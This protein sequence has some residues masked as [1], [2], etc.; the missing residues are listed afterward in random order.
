M[1][2][3]NSQN[4]LL[5][6]SN[7]R[8]PKAWGE[9]YGNRSATPCFIIKFQNRSK[10]INS[11]LQDQIKSFE[12]IY[13]HQRIQVVFNFQMEIV[14]RFVHLCVEGVGLRIYKFNGPAFIGPISFGMNKNVK[15][16]RAWESYMCMFSKLKLV[17]LHLSEVKLI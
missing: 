6:T 5:F 4:L 3:W 14:R 2:C 16:L 15:F 12:I 11:N 17:H 9:A 8:H 1:K 10:E 7:H 13:N